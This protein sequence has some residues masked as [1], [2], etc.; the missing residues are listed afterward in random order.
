MAKLHHIVLLA[1]CLIISIFCS[2]CPGKNSE[3]QASATADIETVA[4]ETAPHETVDTEIVISATV[5]DVDG[6]DATLRIKEGDNIYFLLTAAKYEAD[7]TPKYH[8]KMFEWTDGKDDSRREL[9]TISTAEME[10]QKDA[11]DTLWN[12]LVVG[13]FPSLIDDEIKRQAIK[14]LREQIEM[15]LQGTEENTEYLFH[16]SPCKS[17]SLIFY[18]TT[19]WDGSGEILG[20]INF[21]GE[22][23]RKKLRK[24][25]EEFSDDFK[26]WTIAFSEN[27]DGSGH[28]LL[29]SFAGVR[30]QYELTKINVPEDSPTRKKREGGTPRLRIYID[31]D[32]KP[33]PNSGLTA[34]S[35]AWQSDFPSSKSNVWEVREE[36]GR[37]Y[38]IRLYDANTWIS[39]TELLAR[40]G[41]KD[42]DFRNNGGI[43]IGNPASNRDESQLDKLHFIPIQ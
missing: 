30:R 5:D 17:Y 20:R 1:F 24:K 28:G 14:V 15:M 38:K 31:E 21:T 40:D 9:G 11:Y 3:L 42:E 13:C 18:Q 33:I 26:Q 43:I 7:N 8:A 27:K 36:I 16:L 19:R 41:I 35:K 12:S 32:G 22:E 23:I 10:K 4:S 34:N 6:K 29:L 2:G 39:P 25:T 37:S